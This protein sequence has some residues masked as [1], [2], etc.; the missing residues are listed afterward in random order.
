MKARRYS[1]SEGPVTIISIHLAPSCTPQHRLPLMYDTALP[2]IAANHPVAPHAAALAL[3]G[4]ITP[5]R[6]Y[7]R[8]TTPYQ[9]PR[10]TGNIALARTTPESRDWVGHR[11]E[12][13]FAPVSG[14]SV[15]LLPLS[16]RTV[17]AAVLNVRWLMLLGLHSTNGLEVQ[18][19]ED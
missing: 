13:L 18:R 11:S 5:L 6:H 2:P 12:T 4:R 1:K 10:A 8:M 16:G 3:I 15:L 9:Q 14:R 19:L 7:C 17:R